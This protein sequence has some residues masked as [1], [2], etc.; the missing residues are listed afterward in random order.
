[1]GGT[2]TTVVRVTCI[3]VV[4]SI[5]GSR[6]APPPARVVVAVLE[7]CMLTVRTEGRVGLRELAT[8]AV[9]GISTSTKSGLLIR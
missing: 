5:T 6:R 8:P 7:S 4:R 3:V 9:R 1:M 2:R